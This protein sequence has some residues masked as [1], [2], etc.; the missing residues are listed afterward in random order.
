MRRWLLKF[1]YDYE[2]I[3]FTDFKNE[4]VSFVAKNQFKQEFQK[5]FLEDFKDEDVVY[6]ECIDPVKYFVK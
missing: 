5:R 1:M 6:G 2:A 4:F 3:Q